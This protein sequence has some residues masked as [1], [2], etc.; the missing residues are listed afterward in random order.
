MCL[1]QH[2]LVV[3]DNMGNKHG[4]LKGIHSFIQQILLYV[5]LLHVLLQMPPLFTL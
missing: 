4:F 1:Q 5:D 2:S 3:E